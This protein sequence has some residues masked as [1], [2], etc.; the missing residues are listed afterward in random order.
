[1]LRI[2]SF[3]F[4]LFKTMSFRPP[5][6]L[7]ILTLFHNANIAQSR[8]ALEM[9][10]RSCRRED[11]SDAYRVDVMDKDDK[12][13]IDQLRQIASFLPKQGAESAWHHMVRPDAHVQDWAEIASV[14]HEDPGLLQRPMVVDW[15]RGAAAIGQPTIDSIE[16]LIKERINQKSS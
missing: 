11:G 12:P 7:P 8:A 14:I 13:T 5:R 10:K 6:T 1:M 4:P 3:S 15:N 9:L 16:Q 2:L